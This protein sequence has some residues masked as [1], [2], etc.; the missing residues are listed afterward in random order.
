MDKYYVYAIRSSKDDRIYVGLSEHPD[1][2][3]DQHNKGK[4]PSTKPW[5]PWVI[6]YQKFVGSRPEARKEEKRLKSGSG[7]EFLKALSIIP[8]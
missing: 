8:R 4:T 7:K 3:L 5:R 1:K 6:I 2:R